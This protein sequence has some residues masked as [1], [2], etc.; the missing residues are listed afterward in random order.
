MISQKVLRPKISSG[1]SIDYD[2]IE[3]QLSTTYDK[4]NFSKS[5]ASMKFSNYLKKKDWKTFVTEYDKKVKSDP[6]IT[7]E[8]LNEYAWKMFE[9]C[10][11]KD[12]LKVALTW[13]KLAVERNE[14]GYIIDTYANLLYKLGDTKNAILWQEKAVSITSEDRR[15][16]LQTNL[17]KMKKGEQTW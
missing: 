2:E 13:S 3:K 10:V 1:E 14:V 15:E 16:E 8:E 6:N 9:E 11:D 5:F 4:V 17:D 7:A 12:A